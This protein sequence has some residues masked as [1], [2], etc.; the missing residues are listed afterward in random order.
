MAVGLGVLFALA[1]GN[2]ANDA[3]KSVAS[4]MTDPETAGFR[5]TYKALLWGGLFSGLGSLSAIIISGNLFSVFTPEEFL[6]STPGYSFILAAVLGAALWILAGTI[7]RFPVSTTH[8]IVGSIIVQAAYLFGTSTLAWNFLVWRVLLPLAAGPFAALVGVYLLDI[9]MRTRR[10]KSE[11]PPRIGAAQW[12]SS[13]A[14][15]YARGVNDAPKMAALGVFL[16]FGTPDESKFLSYLVVGAAVVVGSLVWGDRVAKTLVGKSVPLGGGQRVRADATTAALLSAGA[17]FGDAFSATQ[18]SAAAEGGSK[19][20]RQVL[21]SSLKGMVL[22][23][24]VTL[25][26]AGTLAVMASFLLS[27]F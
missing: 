21:K 14:A 20:G 18:V 13:A 25:P 2:G 17:V 10:A 16:L 3:G 6:Q 12:G 1:F 27:Y 19:R 7:F 22:A 24:G 26:M 5:P 11:G 15:A 23:W 9:L 8:A 4:L